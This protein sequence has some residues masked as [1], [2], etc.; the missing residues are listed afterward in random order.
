MSYGKKA[1]L[2]VNNSKNKY[3]N[4]DP[5]AKEG[6]NNLIDLF[7]EELFEL[8]KETERYKPEILIGTSGSFATICDL[9]YQVRGDYW[10]L[11]FVELINLK[12]LYEFT[13]KH[14]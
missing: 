2:W 9:I 3:H 4:T 10:Q 12:P 1:I 11:K 14:S 13:Q 5:I 7:N 6:I 8:F